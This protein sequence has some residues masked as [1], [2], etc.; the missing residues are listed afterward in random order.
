MGTLVV[1]SWFASALAALGICVGNDA[2]ARIGHGSLG[3]AGNVFPLAYLDKGVLWVQLRWLAERTDVRLSPRPGLKRVELKR[4]GVSATVTPGQAWL[5]SDGKSVALPAAPYVS[6]GRIMV[7]L[8]PVAGALGFKVHFDGHR[9]CAWVEPGFQLPVVPRVTGGVASQEGRLV[10]VPSPALQASIR[11]RFPGWGLP[12]WSD[13]SEEVVRDLEKPTRQCHLGPWACAGDFDG[14]EQTDVALSLKHGNHC[15]LVSFQRGRHG[16]GFVPIVIMRPHA[17][18]AEPSITFLESVPPGEVPYWQEVGPGE[19][20]KTGR[21]NL[22][23]HGIQ[24]IFSGKA[25]VLYY[26]KDGA[27]ARVTTAD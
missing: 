2:A 23:N 21:L 12:S 6:V 20:D 5:N 24:V 3:R 15:Q 13:Y 22:K 9:K 7:P 16:K 25:A 11:R 26:W 8:R 18:P 1:I 19:Y 17:G 14:D 27:F 10:F 4:E